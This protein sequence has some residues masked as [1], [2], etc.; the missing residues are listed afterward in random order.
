MVDVISRYP[1]IEP[2]R[3]QKRP[4]LKDRILSV[5]WFVVGAFGFG[6]PI[7][8]RRLMYGSDPTNDP[9]SIDFVPESRPA[10]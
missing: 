9:Y 3:T 6:V 5:Y 10:R 2:M 8:D 1:R 7:V 4:T